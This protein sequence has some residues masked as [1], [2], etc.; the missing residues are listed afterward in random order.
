MFG[1]YLQVNSSTCAL[2][3]GGGLK[4][5]GNNLNGA[6]GDGTLVNKSTPVDVSGLTSGVV[7][8]DVGTGQ[9]CALTDAGGVACWGNDALGR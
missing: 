9:A 6:V 8:V 1:T 5:W 7:A 2:L 4:C 3:T